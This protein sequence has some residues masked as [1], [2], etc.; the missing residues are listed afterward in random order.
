MKA[1]QLRLLVFWT[2]V[3]GVLL[4]AASVGRAQVQSNTVVVKATKHAFAPPLSQVVP[5]PPPSEQLSL[6]PDGDDFP[7]HG[8]RATGL[9]KDSVLQESPDEALPSGLSTLSTTPGQNFLGIGTGLNGFVDQFAVPDTNGNVGPTQFVEWINYSFA[10]FDK[11]NGSLAYG[12]AAGNTLWQ[13]LGG[14]CYNHNNL[15]PI[16]QFDKLAQRWVMMMP[17]FQAPFYLCVAVSNTSDAITG[18]WDLYQ[19]TIPNRVDPDY[20]KMGVW[21]DG[22]YV[23]YNQYNSVG[24]VGAAAC[25]LDRNSMLASAAATMQCFTNISVAYDVLLPGD[26]DGK[27][28]PPT[29]SPAYF[30][31]YD[32]NDQSLDLWQFHVDWTT[33]SNST[34]TGPTNIPVAAF[35]D[36]CGESAPPLGQVDGPCIP[37]A[38]TQQMLNSYED[39]VMYRLAYRHFADH[40]SLLASHTV[41]TGTAPN[42]TGIRWYE[43][44]KTTAGFGLYQQGTYAPDSS[45]RWMGSIAMD[46]LGDIALGYSVSSSTLNPSI[47]YTGRVPSDALGQMESEI[48][49]LSSASVAHSSQINSS[50]WGDYSSMVIDS[51]DDCTFWYM[52]EYQPTLGTH[53]STRIASFSF[54][55]CTS[56]LPWAV[57]NMASNTGNPISNL[58]IPATGTGHL[59]A[60]AIMMNANASVAGVSD[61]ATGGSSL[62][63]SAGA[64]STLSGLSTEIWYA[65]NSK[66]GATIVTPTFVG[67]PTHVEITVWEVSGVS[68]FAP[69]ATNTSTGTVVQNTLGPAVTTTQAGDF[70]V[71]V[72]F[73]G[74]A[75][76]SGISTGNEFT[77]DF[78]TGGNGW[79]HI[80]SNSSGAGTHQASWYTVAPA[81]KYCAS[82]VAFFP[83]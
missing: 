31:N 63:I 65:V 33:P 66:P 42:N 4:A 10:V 72:L 54:P 41:N 49:V 17:E 35:T 40:E 46:K 9:V 24:F 37:Q 23:S 80:T 52:N 58:T 64:R 19:F 82:T 34:F 29:G 57:V 12:P 20:P 25:A 75:T 83:N 16:V 11:S 81:G 50:S 60:V 44:Q 48:D 30:L 28:P 13:A 15:D 45:Y 26:L 38:G 74:K 69:D 8:P 18:G 78:K 6:L 21:P 77:N 14:P 51:T 43:L 27:V 7:V 32:A 59:L 67:S 70:I 36:L 5:I 39:R 79:A 73:A 47:R 68:M 22:Y 61:N 76:L 1:I 3:M 62:Y 53:W 55:S 2:L 71:S 56:P